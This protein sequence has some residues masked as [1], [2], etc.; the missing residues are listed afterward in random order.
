[1]TLLQ[2]KK[3]DEGYLVTYQGHI[4]ICLTLAEAKKFAS[5]YINSST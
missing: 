1:M 2:I 3:I 4:K 5:F